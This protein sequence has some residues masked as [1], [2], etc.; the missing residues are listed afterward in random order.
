MSDPRITPDP[1]RTGLN[2]AAQIGR[3]VVNLLRK[4]NGARD[5]QLLMGADVTVMWRED[6]WAYVKSAADGYCGYVG[7]ASLTAPQT[8]THKVSAASSHGYQN[9]NFKSIDRCAIS[10]GSKLAMLDEK[11]GFIRTTHGFVSKKHLTPIDAM[12]TD[13]ASVA[14]LYLDTPYLWGGN[15]RWGIDCSGLV[16]AACMACG[17]PCPGD[18]DLQEATLGEILPDGSLP[19]RND[20]LFWKGHVA[21]VWDEETVIHANAHAMGCVLEPIEDAIAR[22]DETDGPITAHRR[23]PIAQ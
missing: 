12:E 13:P 7:V 11:D 20:L 9:A 8:L 10:H 5:R 14:A 15:S 23:L 1:T 3:G 19:Q 21:L 6:G 18:S 22:I 17:I 16:Q 2:E 4:P